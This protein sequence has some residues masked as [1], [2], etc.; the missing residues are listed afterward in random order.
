MRFEHCA[1]GHPLVD[2]DLK[3]N[4]VFHGS[5]IAIDSPDV[6]T[7]CAQR[8]LCSERKHP[9]GCRAEPRP[10]GPPRAIRQCR[11]I[12]C[13]EFEPCR[14]GSYDNH[15]RFSSE[16]AILVVSSLHANY[17]VGATR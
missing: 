14:R 15:V 8:L 12:G 2:R 11:M 4:Q 17:D 1:K 9:A 13:L 16:L 6:L 7:E 5:N 3:V 10:S